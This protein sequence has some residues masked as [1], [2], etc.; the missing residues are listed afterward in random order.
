MNDMRITLLDGE[1]SMGIYHDKREAE[2]QDAIK[3]DFLE[4]AGKPEWKVFKADQLRIGI[5]LDEA[6]ALWE[7]LTTA[8]E[9]CDA[10]RSKTVAKKTKTART[11]K[12]RLP[13]VP[14]GT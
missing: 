1:L 2:G 7:Q 14:L 5:S 3:L 4:T 13:R 9:E 8:I 11:K 6:K 10:L 12:C